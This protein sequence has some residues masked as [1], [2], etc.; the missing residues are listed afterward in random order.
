MIQ[1]L[2]LQKAFPV[3][4]I[5]ITTSNTNPSTFI[6]GSWERYAKGRTLV[7]VDEGDADFVAGKTGGEKTHKLTIQEMPSHSHSI[8]FHQG[9]NSSGNPGVYGTVYDKYDT[10]H[11][12]GDQAHN[13]LQPYISVYIWRRTA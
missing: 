9:N 5:F 4:S 8:N 7:G 10:S 2:I 12:G 3:G 1:T 6:G 11:T 13:N